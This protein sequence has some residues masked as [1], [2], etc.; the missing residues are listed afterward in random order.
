MTG[1]PLTVRALSSELNAEAALAKRCE[2]E[3]AELM[4]VVLFAQVVLPAAR[5]GQDERR[6][7]GWGVPLRLRGGV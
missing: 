4:A 7:E 5:R 2:I 3:Q 1:E 6:A